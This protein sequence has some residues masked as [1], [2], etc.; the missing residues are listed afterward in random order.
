VFS[1][2][3]STSEPALAPVICVTPLGSARQAISGRIATPTARP[4]GHSALDAG[5]LVSTQLDVAPTTKRACCL[6]DD[7]RQGASCSDQAVPASIA[8]KLASAIGQ[9]EAAAAQTGRKAKR[10]RTSALR[11]LAKAAEGGDKGGHGAASEDIQGLRRRSGE[12]HPPGQDVAVVALT[13]G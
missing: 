6:I 8:K 4:R 7:A 3:E 11:L 13:A 2:R 12:R 1:F 5:S 10:L 9:A